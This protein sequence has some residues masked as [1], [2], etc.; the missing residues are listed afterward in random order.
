MRFHNSYSLVS[1]SVSVVV[2]L[3]SLSSLGLFELESLDRLRRD[4]RRSRRRGRHGHP[5]VLEERVE[6]KLLLL[7]LLLALCGEGLVGHVGAQADAHRAAHVADQPLLAPT[8]RLPCCLLPR[9]GL[10][11]RRCSFCY[12]PRLRSS[13]SS[14][15]CFA[16][17]AMLAPRKGGVAAAPVLR[18]HG[19]DLLLFPATA[20]PSFSAVSACPVRVDLPTW[21]CATALGTFPIPAA[22]PRPSEPRACAPV[23]RRSDLVRLRPPSLYVSPL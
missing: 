15:R 2:T 14:V 9:W 22:C 5:A 13:R 18:R 6:H 16:N 4:H 7:Q 20:A 17:S 19:V 23:R 21:R 12:C 10:L 1:V 11:E 8:N 3:G